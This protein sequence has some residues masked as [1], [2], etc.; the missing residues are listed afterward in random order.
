MLCFGFHTRRL[1][2]GVWAE[3]VALDFRELDCVTECAKEKMGRS[4]CC[5][6]DSKRQRLPEETRLPEG[7]T[8][9]TL[10]LVRLSAACMF[11][12][13]QHRCACT[14]GWRTARTV[15]PHTPN[16]L[17]RS[18]APQTASVQTAGHLR[19]TSEWADWWFQKP[20]VYLLT[21]CQK[22]IISFFHTFDI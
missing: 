7:L 10:L 21:C 19:V 12:A 11:C 18:H 5:G 2:L 3:P 4:L 16:Q 22:Q 13:A 8:R 17:P 14:G 1:T 9:L 15:L 20:S 6:G